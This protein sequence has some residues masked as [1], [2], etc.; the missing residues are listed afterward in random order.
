[1]IDC[2]N[3]DGEATVQIRLKSGVTQAICQT[4]ADIF[5]RG[6]M[7]P[8]AL[9]ITLDDEPMRPDP[10]PS[11]NYTITTPE[12]V[13]YTPWTNGYAVGFKCTHDD[14]RVE[15]LY[16]NPSSETDDGKPNAFVYQGPVGDP[17]VDPA[18]H[19]YLVLQSHKE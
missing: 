1:M 17:A 14:G 9:T 11:L 15:Y 13:T 12:D 16:L 5:S 6:Q 8:N 2:H 3:C 18:Q 4:C 10:P 19:H 7:N